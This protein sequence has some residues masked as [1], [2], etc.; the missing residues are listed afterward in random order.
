M[1][2]GSISTH[3]PLPT[4]DLVS[5]TSMSGSEGTRSTKE[6]I[7]NLIT[8]MD[9]VSSDKQ[10]D[11]RKHV[12]SMMTAPDL[13]QML[14]FVTAF[15]STMNQEAQRSGEPFS[16]RVE[17]YTDPSTANPTIMLVGH[18]KRAGQEATV[19]D[20]RKVTASKAEADKAISESE[21]GQGFDDLAAYD[22]TREHEAGS[23]S[24]RDVKAEVLNETTHTSLSKDD[25][26]TKTT[27]ASDDEVA[28]DPSEDLTTGNQSETERAKENV[29]QQLVESMKNSNIDEVEKII[30][31]N[32]K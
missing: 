11:A 21:M 30:N 2:T 1:A 3:S 29:E 14:F 20:M 13:V 32:E 28:F 26:K 19:L 31:K 12:T 23:K 6:M 24:L 9:L 7:L 16:I 5:P 8:T 25:E 22:L 27:Q 17:Q 15:K 10:D 4:L 18:V